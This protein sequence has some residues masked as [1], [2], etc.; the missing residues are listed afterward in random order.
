MYVAIR[1]VI[2]LTIGLVCQRLHVICLP[3]HLWNA[4]SR[5]LRG[6]RLELLHVL[7]N[8]SHVKETE[9]SCV[10]G[11]DSFYLLHAGIWPLHLLHHL[12]LLLGVL[13]HLHVVSL[14]HLLLV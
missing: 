4:L 14:V 6:R 11:Y 9:L 1:V 5:R 12:L 13:L 8:L 3:W 10:L 7:V 2:P